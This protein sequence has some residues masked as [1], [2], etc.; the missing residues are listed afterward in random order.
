MLRTVRALCL[1]LCVCVRLSGCVC[2]CVV[3]D[4][5]K[6]RENEIAR[7]H[8]LKKEGNICSVSAR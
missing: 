5:K 4:D 6:N 8:T 3:C 2:V 7:A 1:L